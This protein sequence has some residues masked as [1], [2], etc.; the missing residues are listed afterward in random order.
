MFVLE[1]DE[2]TAHNLTDLDAIGPGFDRQRAN[3]PRSESSDSVTSIRLPG[4]AGQRARWSEAL[5]QGCGEALIGEDLE[6]TIVS[7]NSAA[8]RL[9]GFAERAVLGRSAGMLV[10]AGLC[11][12][13]RELNLRVMFGRPTEPYETRRRCRDGRELEVLLTQSPVI[14]ECGLV[15]GI[16]TV[17]RDISVQKRA[18]ARLRDLAEHDALTGLYSRRR[19][20]DELQRAVARSARYQQRLSIVMID[21]D[22]L[23]RVN[24]TLGHS[25]GDQLLRAAAKALAR[26]TRAADLLARLGGDEFA[27]ILPNTADGQ[28]G[29]L[30]DNLLGALRRCRP[31]LRGQRT[32]I[33]ASI[34]IATL[35]DH[36]SPERLYDDA[37]RAMYAAK[38]QG[39]DR[40]VNP[41]DCL[42]CSSSDGRSGSLRRSVVR[43]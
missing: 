11:H 19:F 1:G 10:P 14:D 22:G 9:F 12:Q 32:T 30:A 43:S 18:E 33:T 21:L 2:P 39:G 17:A 41:V 6:G 8:E 28:A 38:R 15:I 3:A 37:D 20:D 4:A 23:K 36:S 16:V 35:C 34:G 24:D 27:A 40:V 42:T 26:R 5:V 29:I 13:A 31:V 7:W 25:A